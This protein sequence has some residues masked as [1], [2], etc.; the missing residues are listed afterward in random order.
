MIWG[1]QDRVFPFDDALHLQDRMKDSRLFPV[2]R[3]GHAFL[4]EDPDRA[5][6]VFG[7]ALASVDSR[8]RQP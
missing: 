6:E 4:Y 7:R 2:D 8:I 3:A 1:K 5:V